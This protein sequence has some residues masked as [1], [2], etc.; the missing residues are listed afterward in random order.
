MQANLAEAG[1]TLNIDTPDTAQFVED[2]FGGNYDLIC[3]G[4]T[5]AVRTP[6]SV[7]PFLQKLNVEGP[8]MVI[9]G[10]KWT[11]D[12]IDSTITELISESDTDKATELAT[13]LDEMVKEGTI[14]SNLYPEMKASVYAKD[15]KG[16]NTI[17][18]GFVDVT[19]FYE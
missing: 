16:F 19:G 18:R 4:D 12:E 3:V 14:C 13:S 1:I 17:E 6:A 7:M 5:P 10:A 8:G 2:A 11:S 15:L 9:G